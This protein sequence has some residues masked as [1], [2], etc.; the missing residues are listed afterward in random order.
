MIL[1]SIFTKNIAF[2]EIVCYCFFGGVYMNRTSTF[3]QRL[4]EFRDS[5]DLTLEALSNIVGFPNQTLSRWERGDRIPKID[6]VSQLADKLGISL[7]WLIGYDVP[8]QENLSA[9]YISPAEIR[10]IEKFRALDA[11]GQ[12]AVLSVL[13]HEYQAISGDGSASALPRQA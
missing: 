9:P 10:M 13:E 12:S 5:R 8:I 1:S 3:S 11:R 7:L 4:R 2:G 6:V